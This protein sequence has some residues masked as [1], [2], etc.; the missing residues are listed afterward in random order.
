MA[1]GPEALL[2]AGVDVAVDFT[3]VEAARTNLAW[4]AANGVHAVVG[5][6]GLTDADLDGFARA[7]TRSTA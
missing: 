1:A 7:F 5:T 6:T 2:D 4:L 3:Q